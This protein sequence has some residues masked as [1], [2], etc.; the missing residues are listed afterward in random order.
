M[1][2]YF[3][4]GASTVLG[5]NLIS[6]LLRRGDCETVYALARPRAF[7]RLRRAAPDEARFVPLA[8]DLG[9]PGLGGEMP[10]NVDHVVHLS[11]TGVANALAFARTA[12]AKAFHQLSP[13]TKDEAL[14][15]GQDDVPVRFY[16]PSAMLGDSRTGEPAGEGDLLALVS[17]L[18]RIPSGLPLAA[19]DLGLADVV[20][21]DHVAAV[22]DHLIHH[23]APSGTS[24]PI[25]A[26]EPLPVHEVYNA[27]AEA[28]G[29]PKVV[30][31]APRA[32][33]A[34]GAAALRLADRLRL[35]RA[36]RKAVLSEIGLSWETLAR[37]RRDAAI[38][39]TA[40]R[41]ALAG[42][43][44]SAP[45]LRDYAHTIYRYWAAN[46][47]PDRVRRSRR[48]KSLAGRR[49]LITG[50]STGI[51]RHTALRVA[52]EGAHVL[53]VAR[54]ADELAALQAEI[55]RHGGTALSYPCDLT[56]GDAVDA[57]VKEVLGE[58][59]GV[60]VLVN[61]AGRS[62][63]R[64]VIDATDRL[65]DYERTMA[66]NYFA[67]VRLTLGLLPSMRERRDGH[68]VNVTTQG[69]QNHTPRFSA[70]LASK[71][72][73]D[74][75]GVV[76]GRELLSHGITFSSVKLPLVSTDMTAPS[77]RFDAFG[78]LPL[79]TV[80]RAASLV[81]KAIVTRKE[82]VSVLLPFG[83][84]AELAALVAPRTTRALGH[85]IGHESMPGR[86][87]DR[88]GLPAVAAA[89]TRMVWR[90]W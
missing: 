25:L 52:R 5:R 36:T 31:T 47:D 41:E 51:G 22:L 32:L 23:D 66:V 57:L 45:P 73:L 85:L 1:T 77:E 35:L 82:T 90:R 67:A 74:E 13:S 86:A 42:S 40:T 84:H 80:E 16:R 59:D 48:R 87:G 56:D 43:G 2:T 44:L 18:S 24:Y 38:D 78:A 15:R 26:A 83:A 46:V 60:D 34:G 29:A 64:S 70:Y 28:A 6:L 50:A 4:T 81:H 12:G 33:A 14:L 76:S 19:P 54:R 71:A 72:A 62:I 89:V 58:H 53:L 68:I 21:A 17:R 69:L 8:G 20:P 11:T 9:E 61:N 75:F 27:F 37:W 88:A 65:H 55:A 3:V 30:V 39:D 63:R 79:M 7:D 49:I 10:A